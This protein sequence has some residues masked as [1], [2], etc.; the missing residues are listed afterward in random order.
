MRIRLDHIFDHLRLR[1]TWK[2][3][4]GEHPKASFSDTKAPK[5]PRNQG[6]N[7]YIFLRDVEAAGSNPVTS[8]TNRREY[9]MV[10]PSIFRLKFI[11]LNLFIS[12][13][14][15]VLRKLL[16]QIFAN[17]RRKTR[18]R[19]LSPRPQKTRQL[20]IAN[21]LFLFFCCPLQHSGSPTAL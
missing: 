6:K 21:C 4:D 16:L 19:I 2:Q 8:T 12:K 3:C 7:R 9:L 18:F 14:W 1:T 20:A 13:K 15:I 17:N 11:D 5:S 10:L